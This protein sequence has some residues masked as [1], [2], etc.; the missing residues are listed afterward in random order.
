[1]FGTEIISY[2]AYIS[3][4]YNLYFLF[5]KQSYNLDRLSSLEDKIVYH[6]MLAKYYQK[7]KDSYPDILKEL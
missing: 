3:L 4:G 7:I 5:R 2:M 1:M 6:Q